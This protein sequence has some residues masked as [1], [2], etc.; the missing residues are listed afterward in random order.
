MAW[1]ADDLVAAVRRRAQLP[2][3][4]A[5]GA[6]TDSDILEFAN[7]EI[8]L[9]LVPLVRRS[10]EDYWTTYEDTAIVSGTA[11]YRVPERAQASGLYAVAIV[12]AAGREW[13]VPR[14]MLSEIGESNAYGGGIDRTRFVMDGADVRLLPTPTVSGYT[15]RMRY[16]RTH[17]TLVPNAQSGPIA[18]FVGFDAVLI[19]TIE[20]EGINGDVLTVAP[21]AWTTGYVLDVYHREPPFGVVALGLEIES[22]TPDAIY[23]TLA[24]VGGVPAAMVDGVHYMASESGETSIVDLPREC[25][26]LL[27]SAITGRVLEVIGDR[28]GAQMAIALYEREKANVESLLTPRV[29]AGKKVVID[30]NS[31]MRRR[32]R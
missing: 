7:E 3:A 21:A 32:R 18:K 29:E 19:Y 26:P 25:W 15:L 6:I 5:D 8:A 27:V 11:A 28:D 16:H 23:D 13:I 9:H 17:A 14:A 2:D 30:R 12:D 24:I 10:R 31:A 1:T 22:V 4:A 20:N